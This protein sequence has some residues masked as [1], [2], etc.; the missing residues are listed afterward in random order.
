M[1][2]PNLSNEIYSWKEFKPLWPLLPQPLKRTLARVEM[3]RCG[4]T[5]VPWS[6]A[7]HYG[8]GAKK[9]RCRR[10]CPKCTARCRR[11]SSTFWPTPRIGWGVPRLIPA[12]RPLRTYSYRTRH[13]VLM[14]DTYGT[15]KVGWELSSQS[16][17]KQLGLDTL[18][19]IP[20]VSW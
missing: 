8:H 18:T 7:F 16:S 12:L 2:V 4:A 13:C 20:V 3:P 9:Q 14:A 5:N 10:G 6:M 11:V 15:H 1:C 19:R 17:H